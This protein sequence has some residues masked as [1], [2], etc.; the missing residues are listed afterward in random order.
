MA[1]SCV[2]KHVVLIRFYKHNS[3]LFIILCLLWAIIYS[4]AF[5]A[6]LTYSFKDLGLVQKFIILILY[7]VS[8]VISIIVVKKRMAVKIMCTKDIMNSTVTVLFSLAIYTIV[9]YASLLISFLFL[10]CADTIGITNLVILGVIKFLPI[11]IAVYVL[12]H[13][14]DAVLC[15]KK[16]SGIRDFIKNYAASYG[17]VSALIILCAILSSIKMIVLYYFF[18]TPLSLILVITAEILYFFASAAMIER[19]IQKFS[20]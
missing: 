13:V 5:Y 6:R 8:N 11:G 17:K 20:L 14:Y 4:A 9:F 1:L 3:V 2:K 7:Y 10:F 18:Y 19:Y 12:Q 15:M 16:N